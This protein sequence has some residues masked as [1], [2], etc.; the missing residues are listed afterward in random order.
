MSRNRESGM[1]LLSVLMI[2]M[3]LSALLV[4]F[5]AIIMADQQAT[6]VTRDQTHAYAAAHA[7]LEN[8]TANLGRST[9]RVDDDPAGVTRV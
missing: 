5:F 8:L 6:G 1:A 7:G 9:Q 2:M 4:G 3:L